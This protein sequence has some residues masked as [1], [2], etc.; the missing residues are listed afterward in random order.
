[1]ARI[2]IFVTQDKTQPRVKMQLR[3]MQI[4]TVH[5]DSKSREV[6]LTPHIFFFLFSLG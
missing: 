1:M 4:F 3:G 6:T 5:V 2:I